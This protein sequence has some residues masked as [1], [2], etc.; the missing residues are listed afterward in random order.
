MVQAL[1]E[2][3]KEFLKISL[4]SKRHLSDVVCTPAC[5]HILTH[6]RSF[7]DSNGHVNSHVGLSVIWDTA[8]LTPY[9]EWDLWCWNQWSIVYLS[10]FTS[11][12]MINLLFFCN[13]TFASTCDVVSVVL[14]L[15]IIY[16]LIVSLD[17]IC[18][19]V[20]VSILE[21]C[22]QHCHITFCCQ[23]IDSSERLSHCLYVHVHKKAYVDCLLYCLRWCGVTENHITYRSGE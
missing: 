9:A 8:H 4:D 15:H 20:C 11:R 5:L 21:L 23:N 6:W 14:S 2:G 22:N 17:P 3:W 13:I 12:Q 7:S 16:K 19:N 1:R 18:W 10:E